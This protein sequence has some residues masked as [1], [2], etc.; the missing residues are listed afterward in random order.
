MTVVTK[1]VVTTVAQDFASG[2]TDTTYVYNILDASG[3]V[4]ATQ[5]LTVTEADFSGLADGTYTANVT[6]N[7]VVATSAPFTVAN[8]VSLQ[9]P[10]SVAV[11]FG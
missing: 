2:T 9:V 11:S 8:D 1:V 6:K 10:Q 3:N 7:S 5:E 4:V